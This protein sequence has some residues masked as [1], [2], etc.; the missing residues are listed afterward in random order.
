MDTASSCSISELIVR[1]GVT[2]ESQSFRVLAGVWL[3]GTQVR[4][5]REHSSCGGGVIRY[6]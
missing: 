2:L 6:K 3:G 4:V 1:E 5:K